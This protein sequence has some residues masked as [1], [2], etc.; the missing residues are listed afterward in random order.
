[1]MVDPI[2]EP[3]NSHHMCAEDTVA[4]NIIRY[5]HIEWCKCFLSYCSYCEYYGY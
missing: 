5:T 1:M 3:I 4:K 2:D